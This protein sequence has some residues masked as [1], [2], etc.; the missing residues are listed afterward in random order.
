MAKQEGLVLRFLTAV[1]NFALTCLILAIAG[2]LVY[3]GVNELSKE[4]RPGILTYLDSAEEDEPPVDAPE[5]VVGVAPVQLSDEFEINRRFLGQIEAAQT[6]NLSFENGGYVTEMLFEEGQAVREGQ[7]LARQDIELLR[8]QRDQVQASRDA[9]QA[10]LE[11]AQAQVLRVETLTERGV[12]GVEQK[13]QTIA[14]RNALVARLAATEAERNALSVQIAKA[15]LIAPFDGFVGERAVDVGET[16]GAGQRILTLSQ[17]GN[18]RF[19]VGVPPHIDIENVS[20]TTVAIG[21]ATH[22]AFLE[23]IRPDL[24]ARTRTRTL[25][26]SVPSLEAYGTG[27]AGALR[28]KDTI[29]GRGTWVS[30]DALREG[31]GNI[32]S[33]L[34]VDEESKVQQVVVEILHIESD[35]AYVDGGFDSGDQVVVEGIHKVVPGQTVTVKN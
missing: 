20:E 8:L 17:R 26:F 7:V 5:T 16:V 9:L 35:V 13:D 19:R 14:T 10:E 34:V 1:F 31:T 6:A 25:I 27:R 29:P 28:A 24:D 15:S 22:N 11:F 12:A 30:T 4:D 2:A 21:D 23:G 3:L 33:V 32:W 18:A